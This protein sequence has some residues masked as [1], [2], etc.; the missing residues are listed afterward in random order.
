M[1]AYVRT[2]G[3]RLIHRATCAWLGAGGVFDP[4]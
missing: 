4:A 2:R 1:S 3:G